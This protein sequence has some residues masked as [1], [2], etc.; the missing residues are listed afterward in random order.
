MAQIYWKEALELLKNDKEL[1][2]SIDFNNETIHIN[3][4]E[5]FNKHKITVPEDLIDYDDD[6]ID[7]SDIPEIT[8]ESLNDGTFSVEVP[9][10]IDKEIAV[11]L[12]KSNLDYNYIINSYLKTFYN[13]M[14]LL[15]KH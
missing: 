10:S 1:T 4:V 2:E 15:N 13:S 14:N 5:I 7:F 11:W 12:K 8:E 3:D 9:V 6:N